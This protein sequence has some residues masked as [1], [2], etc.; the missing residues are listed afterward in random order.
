MKS[1][2]KHIVAVAVAS[3]MGVIGAFTANNQPAKVEAASEVISIKY[4]PNYGIAVWN[5]PNAARQTTGQ[6][7]KHATAWKVIGSTQVAGQTWYQLGANQWIPAQYTV[8]GYLQVAQAPSAAQKVINLAKAQL[9]KPYAWGA[10]GP[11]A[12]DCS[13]LMYYVFKNALGKNIGG[14]TG[15]QE[16]AGQRVSIGALKAGDLVFW[17]GVG[18][19]YHVG[20]Y[21]GGNQY[22]HAPAPGQG[23][24]IQSISGYFMP[25]FGVR[26]L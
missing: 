14:F 25:S 8:K 23:V 16:H 4:V 12:F 11:Y 13:G 21:L 20:L 3:L 2:T 7:L 9:G 26:V 18:A 19:T 17:G 15:A 1:M 6:T 10:K 24:K 22:L 5:S